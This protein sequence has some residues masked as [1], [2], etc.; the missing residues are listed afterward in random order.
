MAALQL[1][2]AEGR[3]DQE[4]VAVCGGSHGGFLAA[5]AIGQHPDAFKAAVLRNPVLNISLMAHVRFYR[6]RR[7][8]GH[9]ST[10]SIQFRVSGKSQR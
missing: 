10:L 9:F 5:H 1:E 2:V 4:R 7:P 8:F 6:H 3:V